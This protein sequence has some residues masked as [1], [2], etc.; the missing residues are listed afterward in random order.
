MRS[1]CWTQDEDWHQKDTSGAMTEATT[2]PKPAKISR[3]EA[4]A[5][6]RLQLIDA[7]IEAI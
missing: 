1:C 7:T 6:R 3:A 2:S 4:K 5:E